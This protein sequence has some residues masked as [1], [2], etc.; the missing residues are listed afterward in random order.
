MPS[1]LGSLRG[2][3]AP[4]SDERPAGGRGTCEACGE[5]LLWAITAGGSRAPLCAKPSDDGNV[6]VFRR[7]GELR[8][9]TLPPRTV[10]V[11]REQGVPLR[12]NHFANCEAADRFKS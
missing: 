8:C 6:L 7:D 10:S 5:P 3:A 9:A 1:G 11:L 2:W 4:V 12:L